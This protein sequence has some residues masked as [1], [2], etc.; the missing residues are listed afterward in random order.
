VY[1]DVYLALGESEFL[2]KKKELSAA[3]S[4]LLLSFRMYLVN[5]D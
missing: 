3:T 1:S 2:H 5:L 4:I